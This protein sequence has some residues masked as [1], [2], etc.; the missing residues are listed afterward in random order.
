MRR[1]AVAI[2]TEAT[3]DGVGHLSLGR[4]GLAAATSSPGARAVLTTEYPDQI[5]LVRSVAGPVGFV[6]RQRELR[7]LEEALAVA[8]AGRPQVVYV[9]ADAGSGK[10]SLLSSF[11][12][13]VTEGMVLEVCAD[14]AET[15]LSY[16]IIDQLQRGALTE[17]GVDPMIVGQGLVD[18][19]DRLQADGQVVI[20]VI[21][22]LQWIDRPSSRALLFALRRLRADTVLTV[23]A[24]RAAGLS[25]PGWARFVAGDSRVTRIRL[26]G[27]TAGDLS[28]MASAL[29]LGIL[30]TRGAA[31]LFAHTGGNPLYC[32]A[33]LQELGVTAL[34]ATDGGGLPAPRDL[35]AV[36]LARVAALSSEAQLFLSAAS[37]LGQHAPVATTA[38]VA[39]LSDAQRGS[40]EAVSAELLVEGPL[41]E[42]TFAHPLFRA[43]IYADLS[44]TNR[45][46]LHALAADVVEGRAGLAHRVAAS[47][48]VDDVLANELEST[49][50]ISNADGDTVAAA[51]ALEHAAALSSTGD[52]R[53]RR[54][55]DAAVAH[56]GAADTDGAARVLASCRVASA[57]RD[58]LLGLLGVYTGSPNT[59]ERLV[60]AW[61]AH[62]PDRE[63]GIGARAATSLANWMVVSGRP[64]EGLIWAERAVAGTDPD[65]A[66][67][68]MARTAQ[69]YSLGTAGQVAEGLTVLN[70]LP[71]AANDVPRT[72]IDALIMRGMLKVY[73][74]DLSG[75]IADLGAA[76]ARL[77][78]GVPAT[79]PVPCLS[80][81][82]EA[83]F[84]RGDWDTAMTYAQ[85]ATSLAQDADRPLDLARAHA[86]SAQILA[87]RGQWSAAAERVAAV[88]EATARFPVVLAVATCAVASVA[89]D[90]AR[91][92]LVGILAATESVHATNR[93]GVG[94]LPGVFNWRSNE[95]DA[96]VGIGRLADAEVALRQF[97]QAIPEPNPPSA[98]LSLARC[99]GNLAA[100]TGDLT[101]ADA[102][103]ERG[104][105]L[106]EVMPLPLEQALLHLDDGRRLRSMGKHPEESVIQLETAHRLFS[107]LGADPFVRRCADELELME[108]S[109][110]AQSPAARLGLSRAEMAVARLVATG[111]TNREVAGEL[112]VS[113]K[114]VEYHLRNC[115]IKLDIASRRELTDLLR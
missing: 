106:A 22:D 62:N 95:V 44:P 102:A 79:Y 90:S 7:V 21:D 31:R 49:A 6:G 99:E 101:R 3:M 51:W 37:V 111:L 92:D 2:S 107:D 40:D 54:L 82:S 67:W 97:E 87:G 103:F 64:E 38:V 9:E 46:R 69:A 71:P 18:L 80:H 8:G 66:L 110:A 45:R 20:M 53:E 115:Y 96:L 32:R 93:L 26:E 4:L 86:R 10:S 1:W 76:A 89:L 43:A 30:S 61:S 25:D 33:L 74:D 5:A 59:E 63:P 104:H 70:C 72:E 113:V 109:A 11:L 28:D 47:L 23:V 68:A 57:R 12:A 42:L 16:G 39:G 108:V 29:E 13:S 77:R 85:L 114:T 94:G 15:L 19:L 84:R 88:R 52:Q 35:S 65:S 34:N 56:L 41:S 78:S 112:Y 73:V 17:P 24:T 100:A 105:A 81:L 75:A 27:L 60:A 36:I 98:M 48:G 83:H 14:E 50:A 91:G 58:A 55:L